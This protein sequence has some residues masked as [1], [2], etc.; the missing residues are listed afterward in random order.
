MKV[1]IIEM[2]EIRVAT[3]RHLG[4]Y[5]R[6]G[7]AFTRLSGLVAS[8]GLFGPETR[9]IA[10][11]LDDPETTPEADLRSDAGVSV[12]ETAPLPE[13]TQEQRIHAGRYARAVHRGSYEGL[14]DSWARFMGLWL[15]ESGERIGE[16]ASFEIYRNT[17]MDVAE[18]E[19]RT[20]LYLPLA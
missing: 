15:P 6:I 20:E 12:A 9:M 1:D 18:P 4:P 13:G 19:L 16:G 8:A 11:Y 5:N 7:E 2:P 17:P 10:L 3:V 14:G